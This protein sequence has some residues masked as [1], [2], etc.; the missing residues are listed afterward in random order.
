MA[1][2][3]DADSTLDLITAVRSGDEQALERLYQRYVPELREWASGRLPQF[4][5]D[6]SDTHDLVQETVVRVFAKLDGFEYRGEGALRAYLRQSLLNRIRNEIR[7]AR[8]R[9]S[10]NPIDSGLVDPA[11]SP[12]AQAISE[13]AIA[14]YT[15][16]LNQLKP[17]EREL[18]IARVDLGLTY[19]EMVTMLGKPS[20]DAA[21]MAVAR[22]LV[23]LTEH[24]G[25]EAAPVSERL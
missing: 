5:R 20:A 23:K 22:A 21:R 9:P 19:Q 3:H 16:A 14:T 15:A 13:Q 12:M 18:V 10:G 1:S 4:A 25:R 6:L 2:G 8:S 7:R 24:M 11:P 17:E